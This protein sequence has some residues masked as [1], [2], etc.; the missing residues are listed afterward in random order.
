MFNIIA[1][2]TSDSSIALEMEGQF[3]HCGKQYSTQ[4]NLLKS[5]GCIPS[6][7]SYIVGEKKKEFTVLIKEKVP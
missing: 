4:R 1:L 5:I 2:F 3:K 7:L 6:I